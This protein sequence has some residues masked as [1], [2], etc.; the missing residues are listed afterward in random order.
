MEEVIKFKEEQLSNKYFA[1]VR[2]YWEH[3]PENANSPPLAFNMEMYANLHK[4]GIVKL[5]VG[6]IANDVIIA[7]ALY[8]IYPNPKHMPSVVAQCDTFAV[9]RKWRGQGIGERLMGHAL[10]MLREVGVNEVINGYREVYGDIVP[11][12]EKLGFARY[13]R[14]Y[15]LELT[16]RTNVATQLELPI[17]ETG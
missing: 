6:R 7:A 10:H 11:L 17:G 2:D 12:F 13:E 14:L 15:R 1:F 8:I 4:S 9:S 3:T 5:M 16:A